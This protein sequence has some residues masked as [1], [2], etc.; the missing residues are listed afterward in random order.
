MR[1]SFPQPPKTIW[2]EHAEVNV[3]PETG[4]IILP[5][6][7]ESQFEEAL[8]SLVWQGKV[9]NSSFAPCPG[10]GSRHGFSARHALP[11]ADAYGS[12]PRH[13]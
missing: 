13:R 5:A 1:G 3:N 11:H 9:T 7:G 6:W 10:L 12:T 8:W 2:Q 4:E